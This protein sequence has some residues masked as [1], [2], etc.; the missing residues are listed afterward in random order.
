M[1]GVNHWAP[2]QQLPLRAEVLIL[3]NQDSASTTSYL[4]HSSVSIPPYCIIKGEATLCSFSV[5][6]R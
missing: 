4:I 6:Y 2:P 3:S 1:Q 5:V